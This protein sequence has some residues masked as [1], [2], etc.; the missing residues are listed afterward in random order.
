MLKIHFRFGVNILKPSTVFPILFNILIKLPV[1][2]YNDGVNVP[3]FDGLNLGAEYT[4]AQY[5]F[6]WGSVSTQGS[7]HTVNGAR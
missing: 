1:N 3:K 2:V 4:F 7:E 6:H 5:H